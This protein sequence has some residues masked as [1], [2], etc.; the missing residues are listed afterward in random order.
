MG[1]AEAGFV[2]WVHGMPGF[3]VDVHV[4]RETQADITEEPCG[5]CLGAWI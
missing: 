4:C 3:C 5:P 1:M 2:L